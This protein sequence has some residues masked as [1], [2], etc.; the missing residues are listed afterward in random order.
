MVPLIVTTQLS[1]RVVAS[2]DCIHW[3]QLPEMHEILVKASASIRTR[4]TGNPAHEYTLQEAGPNADETRPELPA[5]VCPL[6][7]LFALPGCALASR[8]S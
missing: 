7:L 3:A 8:H 4:F 1:W 6:S 2:L 5:E